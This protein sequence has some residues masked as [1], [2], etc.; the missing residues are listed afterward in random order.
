MNFQT[1]D[2][3]IPKS[4]TSKSFSLGPQSFEPPL[5]LISAELRN[6]PFIAQTLDKNLWTDQLR[7]WPFPMEG[8][9]NWYKRVAKDHE[10]DWQKI[11]IA[12]A[13]SLTLSPIEKHEN[14]L[15]S[16][17]Y[18]W[19][20]TLNYFMFDCG[21][22]TPTLMDVVMILGLNIYSTCPSPFCSDRV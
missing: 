16:I 11:E 15:R 10:A 1:S 17:G 8:W 2:I 4:P 12:D 20:D 9:V 5:D 3:L 14:L 22:M 7:A 18:F 13:L 19:S 6:I 21:S